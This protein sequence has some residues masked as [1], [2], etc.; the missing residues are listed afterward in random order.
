MEETTPSSTPSTKGSQ[1]GITTII[2]VVIIALLVVGG[3]IVYGMNKNKGAVTTGTEKLEKMSANS[4]SDSMQKTP[5]EAASSPSGAMGEQMI[6]G[7]K[8]ITISGSNYAFAPKI[9][10]VS[11]GEN[12]T[13]N[14]KNTG[15]FHDF[16]IDEFDVKTEVIGNG[17]EAKVTF[18]AD[19]AGTYQYYC[20]VGNHRAMGMVGTLI[21][22]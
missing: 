11:K 13:I 2:A 20:S 15:G 19:K 21:V 8:M 9:I 6:V 10:T 16:V 17:K 3:V 14:F 22:K 5:T 18:V 12:I 7:G 4:A 1:R